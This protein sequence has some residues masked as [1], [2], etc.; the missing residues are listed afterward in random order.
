MRTADEELHVV[1][2]SYFWLFGRRIG[3]GA[4]EACLLTYLCALNFILSTVTFTPTCNWEWAQ[5]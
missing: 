5:A 2:L 3:V 4:F 1:F